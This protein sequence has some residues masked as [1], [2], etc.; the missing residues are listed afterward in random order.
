MFEAAIAGI[1]DLFFEFAELERFL[2]EENKEARRL[3][4][5]SEGDIYYRYFEDYIESILSGSNLQISYLTS[6]RSD[7]LFSLGN[8]RVRPFYIKNLLNAAFSRLDSKVLVMT[9][10]DLNNCAV[11]RAPDP[12]HHIYVFHGI[13]SVH[14][15]YRTGAFDHYDS[16]FC[17]AP[18][19]VKELRML[20]EMNKLK[21]K[22]LIE[23]GYP[24]AERLHRQ[25]L[26]FLSERPAAAAPVCL[27]AP[28]WGPSSIMEH[29]IY[30]LLE[31][32]EE[33]D[34][35]VWIRPHPQYLRQK[36]KEL[37]ELKKFLAS[38]AKLILKP[39]DSTLDAIHQA[40][41]L[42]TDYSGIAYE[43]AL[44]TERSVI[45]IDTPQRIDNPDAGRLGL[46]PVENYYR[47]KL[48]ARVKLTEIGKIAEIAEQLYGQRREFKSSIQELRGRLLSN[49]GSSAEIGAAYIIDLL[50]K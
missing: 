34:F 49:W 31:S 20:E 44:S 11:R 1:K 33:T 17:I 8:E 19:Q 42:V 50:S 32:L 10:P 35:E 22:N 2:S 16:I 12:V 4:F 6:S 30:E 28:T 46:E 27:I 29:C 36:S 39:P 41:L 48:G 9:A 15:M 45:F 43:Y 14:Q 40:D 18:Y 37:A 25:H 5:Y 21:A 3:V 26:Q 13:S 23:T 7:P 38:R 24:L 47:N